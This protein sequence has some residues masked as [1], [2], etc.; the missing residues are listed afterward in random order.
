[1]SMS[2]VE[3]FLEHYGIRGQRWGVRTGGASGSSGDSKGLKGP[4]SKTAH[5]SNDELKKVVERIKL[6][7]QYHELTNSKKQGGKKYATGLLKESGG[8]LL[9]AAVT[10]IGTVA[11]GIALGKV[12]ARNQATNELHKE[13][14]KKSMATAVAARSSFKFP[15]PKLP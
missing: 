13:A 6:D 12:V 2:E 15:P 11:V 5:L 9:G 8:K 10:A 1:M 4:K 14:F 7:Q 3:S